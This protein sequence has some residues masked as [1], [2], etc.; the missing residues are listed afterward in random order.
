MADEQLELDLED[1]DKAVKAKA[2][3]EDDD[4]SFEVEI[5]DDV[6]EDKKPRRELDAKAEIPD[7]DDLENYSESVQKRL[8]KLTFEAK[9]AERQAEESRR[10]REEAI[11][12][13][14]RVAKDNERLRKQYEESQGKVAETSKTKAESEVAAAKAAYKQAYE[15][16]D[17][18]ALLAAQ[19]RLTTAQNDLY[20]W[21][22]FKPEPQQT[23]PVQ[24]PQ[25]QQQP[26]RPQLNELQQKWLS[27]NSWFGKNEEMT[28]YAYGLHERLVKSGVDPN[29]QE[30][31]DRISTSVR[32]RFAEEFPDDQV[33]EVKPAPKKPAN[34]VASAERSVKNPRKIT[35]TSSQVSIAKRL[36]LTAEQYA[37]QLLKEA[38][39]G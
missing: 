37:A 14:Q 28:G 4:D 8:K 39:N 11:S 18:D 25:R 21:S 24:Q 15:A 27:E 30:Y 33:K 12:Y 31:Y 32:Q 19:E 7:D 5:V 35:L 16:G 26:Q 1:D 2:S 9:E 34:V 6:P 36:G 22:N 10:L 17:S 20:R 3:A 23:V 13:A 29:S 38:K